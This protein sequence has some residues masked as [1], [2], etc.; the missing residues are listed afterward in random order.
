VRAVEGA[1]PPVKGSM[2]CIDCKPKKE[3]KT[4]QRDSTRL[5]TQRNIFT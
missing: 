4:F 2:V 5:Y 1:G 3:G